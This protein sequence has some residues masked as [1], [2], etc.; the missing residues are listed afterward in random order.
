[1]S[2]RRKRSTESA[3]SMTTEQII[4]PALASKLITPQ[5]P[6][7]QTVSTN[8]SASSI[9]STESS[10]S[11]TFDKDRILP[12]CPESPSTPPDPDDGSNLFTPEKQHEIPARPTRHVSSNHQIPSPKTF[13]MYQL[14]LPDDTPLKKKGRPSRK[15][16]TR[17]FSASPRLNATTHDPENKKSLAQHLNSNQE[18]LSAKFNDTKKL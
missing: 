18:I 3:P 1:M 12:C 10:S 5:R 16:I 17:D 11:R 8:S 9:S 7:P 15:S 2:A 6:K 13:N 14:E 4:V